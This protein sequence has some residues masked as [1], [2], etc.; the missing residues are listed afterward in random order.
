MRDAEGKD[1]RMEGSSP[2]IEEE[3]TASF[4]VYHPCYFLQQALRALLKCVGID[5]SENT[6]CSQANK[7]EKSS[8][9]QTPSADDP[10]TNMKPTFPTKSTFKPKTKCLKLT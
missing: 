8:L 2:S 9:P 5:E 10:I 3:R 1:R 7:Q 6:M 4:Y